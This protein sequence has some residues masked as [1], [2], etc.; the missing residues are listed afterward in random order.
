MGI[1]YRLFILTLLT[2]GIVLS[3]I[4]GTDLCNFGGCTEAHQYR[5]YGLSFPVM[6]ILFFTL[7]GLLILLANRLRFS[8]P[9]FNLF[10]AGACGAEINM[11]LL[12]KNVIKAWCPVCLGIA[13]VIYVLSLGQ[14]VRDFILNKEKRYMKF[15]SISKQALILATAL[16]GFTIAFTGMTKQDAVAGQL[17]VS[18]GKQDSKLEVYLF[19]DWLCPVCVKVEGVIESIYPALS[20]KSRILFVDKIIHPEA[21]NFVPYHLSFAAHE[22]AKYLQLRKA[23]FTIAQK[24]KNPSSDDI[25]TAITPL[26]VEYKQLSF[27]EVTQ[28]MSEFQKLGDKLKITSTPTM[29]IRNATTNKIRI[30]VGSSEITSE[31]IVKAITDV[32]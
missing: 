16:I 19:S 26:K 23:L 11:I 32:E 28:Q 15:K 6:G 22:K 18:L 4:S 3:I 1:R 13:A 24:T 2:V 27:L 7:S 9:A 17:N 10:L 8:G 5:L 14:I 25:K 31:L 29:V 30:L 21:A 12:Q 20:K